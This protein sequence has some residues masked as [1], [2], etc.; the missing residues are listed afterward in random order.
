MEGGRA[1]SAA[2]SAKVL[3]AMGMFG[4]VRMLQILV[5]IIRTKLIAVWLG[6]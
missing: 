6:P 4:G 2:V 5:G 3:K 1:M